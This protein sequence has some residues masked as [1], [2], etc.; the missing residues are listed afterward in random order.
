MRENLLEVDDAI[1][2]LLELFKPLDSEN[3]KVIEAFGRILA[4]NIH[5]R[6]DLPIYTNSAMDGFAVR[7]EDVIEASEENP[8]K[9]SIVEDIPAGDIPNEKVGPG[10]TAR[11]MTGAIIPGGANA[12]IPIEHTSHFQRKDG[13]ST[14]D[15]VEVFKPAKHGAYI[16]VRGEDVSRDEIIINRGVKLQSQHVG[17]LA[18]SGYSEIPV[19]RKPKVAILS[20]GDELLSPG[21]SLSPGKMY[22]ANTVTLSTLIHQAGG[23]TYILGIVPDKY[24]QIQGSLDDAIANDVDI[25]ISSGGV[26]VGAFDFIKNVIIDHGKIE[27]WRVN[28]RPGKPF[29]SGYYQNIPYFGL[30]GNPVSAFIT[31]EVFVRPVIRKLCGQNITGKDAQKVKLSEPIISDG[32]ESYLRAVVFYRDGELFARLT[33]HQGSGNLRSLVQANALVIIPSGVKYVPANEIIDVW[34]MRDM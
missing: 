24:H 14:L 8:I 12:I 28:I 17:L 7:E 13:S 4:G 16:R 6:M 23:E 18:M 10:Q 20:V 22:D 5:S 9:L 3:V 30:P 21:Q 33:G 26:S 2:K 34:F 11:I 1:Y 29:L 19:F 15:T 31:F 32:R 27:F 25:I